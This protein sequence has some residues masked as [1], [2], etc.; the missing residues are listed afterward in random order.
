M[1]TR[2]GRLL[3]SETGQV[4]VTIH[5]LSYGLNSFQHSEDRELT[6]NRNLNNEEYRRECG[7]HRGGGAAG[8]R[9]PDCGSDGGCFQTGRGT[10][11]L[12]RGATRGYGNGEEWA[13]CAQDCSDFE[14]DGDSCAISASGGGA[15]R[16]F[17]NGGARGCGAGAVSE[18]RDGGD[19]GITGD[20]QETA[21]AADFDD[22]RCNL[23]RAQ[24]PKQ[25]AKSPTSRAQNAREMGHPRWA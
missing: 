22:R 3:W 16:G 20:D 9:G 23:R 12:L 7:A 24:S 18:R 11:V 14:F 6:R 13:D 21:G 25:S 4:F 17:G 8:A 2:Q 1:R 15:A 19:A 5:H 10:D